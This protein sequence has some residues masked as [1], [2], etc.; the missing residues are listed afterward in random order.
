[1]TFLEICQRLR[2]KA[3]VS[4]SGPTNVTGQV[5]ELDLLVNLVKN[6]WLDIQN[7]K[8]TWNFLWVEGQELTIVPDGGPYNVA[9]FNRFATRPTVDGTNWLTEIDYFTYKSRYDVSVTVRARPNNIIVRPDR[10]IIF[11]NNP[12]TNHTVNFD[13]Y[14][15]PQELLV[16]S[17]VPLMPARHHMVIVWFA[18]L[19]YAQ[20][21]EANNL[22][23]TADLEYKKVMASLQNDQLPTS[24]VLTTPLA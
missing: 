23:S 21:E 18:L 13:Y 9:N 24:Q 12:S 20:G 10:K 11:E 7:L 17:D 4:G 6:A 22:I 3:G 2:E 16:S 5:G 14:R 19:R 1:M 15:T 8:K